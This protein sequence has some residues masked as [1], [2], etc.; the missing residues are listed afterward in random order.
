MKR[1]TFLSVIVPVYNEEGNVV[2]LFE[3]VQ[4]S[5]KD[6]IREKYI[7]DYEVIFVNDGSRDGT[8]QKLRALSNKWKNLHIIELRRN[9]GQTA[10]LRAGFDYAKGDLIV[11]MDGDMQ[12]DPRDIK[13]LIQT[14]NKGYDVVSGWRYRRRDSPSKKLFSRMMN[15]LRRRV[16]GDR[17][18]DYGCSLKIYRRECIQD[19]ELYGELHRFI[20]A[21]LHIKG[22]RIGEVQVNHRERKSGVTKYRF[23]R[24]LNGL[25][26]LFFLRFWT[27]FSTQPLHFFGRI[28]I[29]QWI[30]AG[31][32]GV[33]QIIKALI[34]QRLDLG[35]MLS[36]GFMLIITGGLC[37]IFGFLFEMLSRIYFNKQK[38]YSIRERY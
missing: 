37:I 14:L 33:E 7:T 24:G 38:V 1:S 3:E 22:Y 18:H 4:A 21:Y 12:N 28:G 10:A 6:L 36:F 17:L 13:I 30:L 31:L 8:S 5:A 29:Y 32:I 27:S 25:L 9:F 19:L 11:T 15:L 2:P 35:P 20:T 23:N 34:L 16:I 26:D